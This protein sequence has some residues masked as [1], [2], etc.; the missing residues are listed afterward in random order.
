M[1]KNIFS[2]F[3]PLMQQLQSTFPVFFS[4]LRVSIQSIIDWRQARLLRF[5][6]LSW[7][8]KIGN[9]T[10]T[11]GWMFILYL[12]LVDLN[13][14]WLFGKSPTLKA[15]ENPEQNIVT[16]IISAD[17]QHIGKFF[18]E[19]RTPVNFEELSPQLI[20]ALIYTEDERFYRHF[21]IDLQGVIATFKDILTGNPR[22]GSTI[23]QQLVKNMFNTRN[24]Y[25]TGI[26]GSIPGFRLLIMKTK[27]WVTAVKIEIFYTKEEI[28][29]MYLNTVDF[30]SGSYG[31][32]TAAKTYFKAHPSEL[33]YLQSA[34]LVGILKATSFYSPVLNPERSKARRNVVLQ[35]LVKPELI[36]QETCD[37]LQQLPLRLDYSVEKSQDGDARYFRTHLARFLEDWEAR[38]GYDIYNDGLKIYVTLDTRLQSYAEEAVEK[39]MKIL[40][41]RFFEH[42]RGQSPWRDENGVEIPEFTEKI[43]RKTEHYT[44]LTKKYGLESDSVMYYLNKPRRMKVFDYTLISKDTML[45]TMD[46][47]RYMNHYLHTGFVAM[48]PTTGHVKAWVGGVNYDFWQY[49]KVAQSKRQ[50]G[51][52]FKLFVYTAA[53]DNGKIGRAHV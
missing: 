47:I 44:R 2:I 18:S 36:S 10:L 13:F 42:W 19:N 12:L 17:N 34:T 48:E 20:D 15:I 4:T 3:S 22:G 35:N 14:L 39:Q 43:A 1:R 37:S 23:T 21:G 30:G 46:S 11:L 26:L 7:K 9:I 32:Y 5:K 31:I 16:T 52:T 51:S 33:N 38:T 41:K 27:E 6:N 49:D 40:Q 8:R 25:S 53:I 24:Q 45:S 50:P 28:L 29:T